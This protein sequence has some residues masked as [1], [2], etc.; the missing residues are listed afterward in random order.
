MGLLQ[1]YAKNLFTKR[2]D[3]GDLSAQPKPPKPPKSKLVIDGKQTY[4]KNPDG[5]K[6]PYEKNIVDKLVDRVFSR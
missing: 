1:R 5:T 2:I 3:Y 6:T 4:Y